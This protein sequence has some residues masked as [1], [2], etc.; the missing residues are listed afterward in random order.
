MPSKLIFVSGFAHGGV[1]ED[2]IPGAIE[3]QFGDPTLPG[4]QTIGDKAERLAAALAEISGPKII[5]AHSMGAVVLMIALQQMEW[6]WMREVEA[7]YLVAPVP[8]VNRWALLTSWRFWR[9]VGLGGV[10]ASVVG[11]LLPWRGAKVPLTTQRRLFG[12][13]GDICSPDSSVAFIQLLAGAYGGD[14]VDFLWRHA[15]IRQKVALVACMRDRCV[16]AAIQVAE[17]AALGVRLFRVETG[18]CGWGSIVSQ[19]L[20]AK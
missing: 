7:I 4:W 14:P 8:L 1:R 17:A 3:P 9:G 19:L 2:V 15:E 20:K 11:L 13:V 5:V 16:L 12:H 6:A 10:L 18:H